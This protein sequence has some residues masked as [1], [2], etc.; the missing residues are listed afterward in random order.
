[1]GGVCPFCETT[2][3]QVM[4][5]HQLRNAGQIVSVGASLLLVT[6][7]HNSLAQWGTHYLRRRAPGITDA[8]A[9]SDTLSYLSS[10]KCD[11]WHRPSGIIRNGQALPRASIS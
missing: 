7:L 5:S 11:F 10:Q 6:T 8:E 4:S 2:T 1:M 3:T 9:A